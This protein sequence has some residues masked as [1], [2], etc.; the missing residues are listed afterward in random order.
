VDVDQPIGIEEIAEA[1]A[2]D[3]IVSLLGPAVLHNVTVRARR[4]PDNPNLLHLTVV[5]KWT[6]RYEQEQQVATTLL[7]GDPAV[8][9]DPAAVRAAVRPLLARLGLYDEAHDASEA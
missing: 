2:R 9:R 6:L 1:V 8:R 5:Y 3:E 4:N 7:L